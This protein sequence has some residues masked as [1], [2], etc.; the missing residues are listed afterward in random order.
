MEQQPPKPQ[1]TARKRKP[2]GARSESRAVVARPVPKPRTGNLV[3]AM[4]RA[5]ISGT[6]A[7]VMSRFK[8]LPHHMQNRTLANVIGETIPGGRWALAAL[9]SCGEE[10]AVG[11]GLPDAKTCSVVLPRYKGESEINFDLT[12]FQTPPAIET[13]SWSIEILSPPIPEIEYIYRIRSDQN[14]LWSEWRVVRL[15]N[16]GNI[17]LASLGPY[18]PGVHAVNDVVIN[19]QIAGTT[20]SEAGYGRYRIVAKGLTIELNAPALANQGRVISGQLSIDQNSEDITVIG[21]SPGASPFIGADT[22]VDA[23]MRMTRLRVPESEQQIVASCPT[24]YQAEAKAGAY[25]VHKFTGSLQGY[26]FNDTIPARYI[27]LASY[28]AADAARSLEYPTSALGLIIQNQDGTSD[29]VFFTPDSRLPS[30][31]PV[32][33]GTTFTPYT[34]RTMALA[35]HLH[36]YISAP[37]QMTMSVTFFLGLSANSGI[38]IASLRV[39]SRTFLECVPSFNNPSIAPFIERSP[40][41][42]PEALELVARIGQTAQDAYPASYNGFGDLLGKILRKVV[43]FGKPIAKVLGFIPGV[44]TIAN[45]ASEGLDALD[46]TLNAMHSAATIA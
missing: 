31:T 27:T 43:D 30:R 38:G 12:M 8:G 6:L 1:R 45:Y 4:Q 26:D 9:D 40:L 7:Q 10:N 2:R 21:Y 11:V 15:P 44:G 29:N 5:N 28:T 3:K 24:A 18:D 41:F 16:F 32:H 36:P 46:S 35:Q 23:S 37:S 33:A 20:M 22:G 14:N 13:T 42:D 39:K 19:E 17:T 34:K 25:I